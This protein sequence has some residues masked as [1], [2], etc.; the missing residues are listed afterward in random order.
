MPNTDHTAAESRPVHGILGSALPPTSSGLDATE[1]PHAIWKEIWFN[2]ESREY[3][4]E[5]AQEIIRRLTDLGAKPINIGINLP[6]MIEQRTIFYNPHWPD[7]KRAA[8]WLVATF[9]E[10][11]G[12]T[13]KGYVNTEASGRGGPLW[14]CIY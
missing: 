2:W 13:L 4:A 3:P 7:S 6:R 1:L 14:I 10:F 9:P 5:K 8:E 11:R 12:F